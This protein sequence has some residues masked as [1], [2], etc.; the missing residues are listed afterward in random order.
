M[1]LLDT[2]RHNFFINEHFSKKQ[3]TNYS[4]I[5]TITNLSTFV[6]ILGFI[7]PFFGVTLWFIA[8]AILQKTII[9]WLTFRCVNCFSLKYTLLDEKQLGAGDGPMMTT[10]RRT[11]K[12]DKCNFE[13][14]H[15]KQKTGNASAVVAEAK[16]RRAEKAIRDYNRAKERE[17]D[18]TKF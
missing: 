12:C 17:N 14:I 13:W 10:V 2:G 1:G 6:L 3:Q 4:I 8:I 9:N 11:Y 7:L 18:P 5:V 15:H 16:K